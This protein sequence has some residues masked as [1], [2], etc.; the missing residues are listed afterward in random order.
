MNVCKR[1]GVQIMPRVEIH[2]AATLAPAA[3]DMK[4]KVTKNVMVCNN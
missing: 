3:L 4:E 2:Q 1:I